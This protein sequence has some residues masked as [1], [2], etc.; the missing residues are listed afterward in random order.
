[1]IY[2]KLPA[3]MLSVLASEKSGS[4]NSVIAGFI[5]NHPEQASEMGIKELADACHAGTGSVSRFCRDYG[6]QDFSELKRLLKEAEFRYEGITGEDT[7][8]RIS[9]WS[10]RMQEVI[11]HTAS[12]LSVS[13]I[14]ELAR[15][16]REYE[17]VSAYGMLKAEAA[18]V[19]LQTDML[20]MGKKIHTAVS[21]ADQI[22]GILQAGRDELIIIFSYTGSYFDY[23]RFGVKERQLYLPEI[24][25]VCGTQRKLP[26]YINDVIRFDSDQ[27]QFGHP[28]Q[29]MEAGS[30]IAA[31]YETIR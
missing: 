5:L 29:L 21:Y 12:S 23:H 9:K 27:D 28:W 25:M 10:H 8:D 26:E 31:E 6:F 11:G 1:M 15:K 18:A 7:A 2:D 14:K 16:I 20:M 22:D 13:K 17:K 24:W 30:L 19:S 3:L 4:T